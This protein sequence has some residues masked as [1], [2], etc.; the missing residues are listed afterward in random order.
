MLRRTAMAL[1]TLLAVFALAATA[2][3]QSYQTGSIGGND[4][5]PDPGQTITVSGTGCGPGEQVNF[6]LDG[7]P[8]GGT[9]ADQNGNF[10]GPLTIPSN[11]APGTHTITATCGA[12]VL[13]FEI[14]VNPVSTGN[15]SRT[16]ASS[17]LPLSG[18]ALGLLTAGGL[19]LLFARRRRLLH[20]AV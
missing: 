18:I 4:T 6:F 3:A 8:A 14:T 11:E 1:T 10:S 5:T 9:T 16:G 17:T 7:Q 2:Q 15:L 13:S 19:L 12:Q 20:S